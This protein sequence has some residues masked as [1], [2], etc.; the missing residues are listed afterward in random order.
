VV[1]RRSG[2]ASSVVSGPLAGA[3]ERRDRRPDD[4]AQ[5]GADGTRDG[6]TALVEDEADAESKDGPEDEPDSRK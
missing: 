3:I 1:A 4:E 6:R 2:L 5:P